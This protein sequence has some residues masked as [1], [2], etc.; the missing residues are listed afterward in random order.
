M[1]KNV[2]M[3]T[4]PTLG[5]LILAALASPA[6]AAKLGDLNLDGFVQFEAW[7]TNNQGSTKQTRYDSFC[8]HQKNTP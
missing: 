5:V 7:G 4:K 2:N 3:F 6:Y 1:R 8:E